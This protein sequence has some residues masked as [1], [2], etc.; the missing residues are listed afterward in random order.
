MNTRS[1]TEAE[2]VAA[3]EVV[4]S[5]IWAKLF[6]EAQGYAVM[7]NVLYQDNQSAMLL[8]A[9]GRQLAGKRSRHLNI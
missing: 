3:D 8:E 4:R 6:L 2:V 7:G 5:M 9:K 1:L